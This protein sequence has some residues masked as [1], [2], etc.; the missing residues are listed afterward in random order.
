MLILNYLIGFVYCKYRQ[1]NIFLEPLFDFFQRK[2]NSLA[3]GL[4]TPLE[5]KLFSPPRHSKNIFS[6]RS[7]G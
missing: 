5:T 7:H 4:K 1:E 2:I 6:W 3:L